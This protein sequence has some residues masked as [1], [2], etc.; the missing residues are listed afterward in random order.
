M[1][2]VVGEIK[3]ITLK[4]RFDYVESAHGRDGLDRVIDSL[5]ERSRAQPGHQAKEE[6]H[7]Q[8]FRKGDAV[9]QARWV[10]GGHSP[11]RSPAHL[12]PSTSYSCPP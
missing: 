9:L 2:P 12:N 11:P 7:K 10:A 6:E 8:D 1:P 5:P 4:G 3:G